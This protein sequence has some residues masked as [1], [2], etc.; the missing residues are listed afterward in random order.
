MPVV[1]L[2]AV[3]GLMLHGALAAARSLGRWGVPVYAFQDARWAPVALSRYVRRTVVWNFDERPAEQ[4]LAR[5]LELAR[6]IGQRPILI[7]TDD[8][9]TLFIASH[10]QALRTSYLLP[11]QPAGLA[12]SVSNKKT[13]YLLCREH[14][15]PAPVTEFPQSRSDVLDFVATAAFPVVLKSYDP[16]L[17]YRRKATS[18]SIARSKGELLE[19]YDRMEVP[20]QP[21]L[22]LQEYI[23]GGPESIWMF[24]GY[25]NAASECLFGLTGR[26][27]RQCPA[28]V[29][30]TTMAV[31][32]HNEIV[33]GTTRDLMRALGYRGILDLGYRYDARDGQYKLLDLNPRIGSTFRLFTAT[34]GMDVARALYLDLT[35][36]PVPPSI[37][38]EGAKWML[39]YPDLFG[40]L[41]Y[42]RDGQRGLGGWLPS[43]RGVRESAWFAIDDLLPFA[44]MSCGFA[45]KGPGDFLKLRARAGR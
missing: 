40:Y 36:Q 43:L 31:C 18:V 26:K 39:E 34:N 22:M 14:G 24:N 41:I 5:L 28:G 13:L 30:A 7:P 21:N 29:G 33:D 17:L 1:L 37:A 25:F 3:R 2:K 38:P 44:A 15:V 20:G 12:R 9:S 45:M 19:L 8:M 6:E 23:P 16:E 27:I 42:Y 35:G 10:T 32:Q 11:D 4:S